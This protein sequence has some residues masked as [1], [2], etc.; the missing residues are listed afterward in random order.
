MFD[1]IYKH[2]SQINVKPCKHN[3]ESVKQELFDALG[4]IEPNKRTGCLNYFFT[5]LLHYCP[6]IES[7]SLLS[8]IMKD[9]FLTDVSYSKL[10]CANGFLYRIRKEF[11]RR[12]WFNPKVDVYYILD[13]LTIIVDVEAEDYEDLKIQEN[14]DV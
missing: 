8:A 12:S 9:Y 1:V 6:N 10:E 4:T 2:A 5:V 14:G 7:F 11:I 3:V 13:L